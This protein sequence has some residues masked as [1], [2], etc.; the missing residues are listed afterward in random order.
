[1]DRFVAG[2]PRQK[3]CKDD[4]V[5]YEDDIADMIHWDGTDWHFFHFS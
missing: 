1:M 4:I 2:R 3:N 5:M